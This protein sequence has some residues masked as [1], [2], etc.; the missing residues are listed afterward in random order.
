MATEIY[1][2]R[3]KF[4]AILVLSIALLYNLTHVLGFFYLY[5]PRTSYTYCD[6]QS[7][8]GNSC[9]PC[10]LHGICIRGDL[11]GCMNGYV[12]QYLGG[13]YRCVRDYEKMTRLDRLDVC[14]DLVLLRR[15]VEYMCY[16]ESFLYRN[17]I[18][19][20]K[21]SLH[22]RV[23]GINENYRS[24]SGQLDLSVANA[25]RNADGAFVI[26]R[27][28]AIEMRDNIEI[29]CPGTASDKNE[30]FNDFQTWVTS[31]QSSKLHEIDSNGFIQF[32]VISRNSSDLL[33]SDLDLYYIIP[34]CYIELR[35]RQIIIPSYL[36]MISVLFRSI[37]VLYRRYRRRRAA[38]RCYHKLRQKLSTH[39]YPV[40][41]EEMKQ[42]ILA[43]N[44]NDTRVLSYVLELVSQDRKINIFPLNRRG[45]VQINWEL[46]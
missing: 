9:Q 7:V 22:H 1:L 16:A 6:L 3:A 43:S 12:L 4:G 19:G 18:V 10:P 24:D 32:P 44:S 41:E 39:G 8:R 33:N 2:H 17:F 15:A 14:A 28:G 13:T 42:T 5:L 20:S 46:M 23:A 38:R 27:L 37:Q 26:Q 36:V 31:T 11:T 45:T 29:Y 21:H 30:Y 40:P 34:L 35:L 25:N